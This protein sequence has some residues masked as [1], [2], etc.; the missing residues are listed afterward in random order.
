MYGLLD[1]VMKLVR[2][3]YERIEGFVF[4]V[5]ERGW[6]FLQPCLLSTRNLLGSNA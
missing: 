6:L 3:L 5:V 1:D 2:G 4:G